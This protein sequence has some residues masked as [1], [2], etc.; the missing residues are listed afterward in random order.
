[1][2]RTLTDEDVNAIAERILVLMAE[3]L[4]KRPEPAPAPAP[5]IAPREAPTPKASKLGYTLAE[6]GEELGMSKATIYRLTTRGL[7][8]PLPYIRTKIFTRQ[9]VERFLAEGDARMKPSRRG[10]YR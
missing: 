1:M 5:P 3:R 9:E 2:T 6:L 7:L 10:S 4:G 8:R